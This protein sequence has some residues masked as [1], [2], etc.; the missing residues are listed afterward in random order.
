MFTSIY[1]M[2]KGKFNSDKGN[3]MSNIKQ[4]NIEKENLSTYNDSNKKVNLTANKTQLIK[5]QYIN[6][7][8]LNNSS[9]KKESKIYNVDPKNNE[10]YFLSYNNYLQNNVYENTNVN[11]TF[12]SKIN[13]YNYITPK[14]Y[15]FGTDSKNKNNQYEIY[16]N[17]NIPVKIGDKYNKENN[18]ELSKSTTN[19]NFPYSFSSINIV[20]ENMNNNHINRKLTNYNNSNYNNYDYFT[21][22]KNNLT[23]SLKEFKSQTQ[24]EGGKKEI[25]ININ[26]KTSS[27]IISKPKTK[28]KNI[29]NNINNNNSCINKIRNKSAKEKPNNYNIYNINNFDNNCNDDNNNCMNNKNNKILELKNYYDNSI[30]NNL[31]QRKTQFNPNINYYRNNINKDYLYNSIKKKKNISVDQYKKEKINNIKVFKNFNGEKDINK[32]KES[33]NY[34][35]NGINYNKYNIEIDNNNYILDDNTSNGYNTYNSTFE[36]KPIKVNINKNNYCGIYKTNNINQRNSVNNKKNKI[37]KYENKRNKSESKNIIIKTDED[38]N[39]TMK[40]NKSN[41]IYINSNKKNEILK[42]NFR[43]NTLDEKKSN[44]EMPSYNFK[45]DNDKYIINEINMN[46]IIN[47]NNNNNKFSRATYIKKNNM[48]SIKKFKEYFTDND[49]I[50]SFNKDKSFK[51]HHSNHNSI[52][53]IQKNINNNQ[54]Y[55]SKN[56]YMKS[57][58]IINKPNKYK[59]EFKGNNNDYKAKLEF[60]RYRV[61]NLLDIYSFL[62]GNKYKK[63]KVDTIHNKNDN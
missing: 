35:T 26:H 33:Q 52:T 14:N 5:K 15:I 30:I 39:I 54:I 48:N 53:K 43:N 27:K 28:I 9:K 4:N 38:E 2:K 50:I 12:K 57:E 61:A 8:S 42:K 20:E 18:R 62:M 24:I 19:F 47:P 55:I 49:R 31:D 51:K 25:N 10:Q 56:N 16:F 21:I 44:Y 41:F 58:K 37:Q 1:Q 63:I 40:R 22:R 60:I 34:H 6:Y 59:N 29:N 7:E 11:E 3:Y 23:N 17:K 32:N 36:S 46:Y 13:S 45:K